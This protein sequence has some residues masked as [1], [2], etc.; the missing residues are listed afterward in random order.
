MNWDSILNVI[1]LSAIPSFMA[2]LG[3]Y[4]ATKENLSRREK[5]FFIASFMALCVISIRIAIHLQVKTD[6]AQEK[7]DTR[8]TDMSGRMGVLMDLVLHPPLNPQ[9]S[10][11]IDRFN[12]TQSHI[13]PPHAPVKTSLPKEHITPTPSKIMVS[14]L[15]PIRMLTNG[16]L[17]T[18]V[19]KLANNMRDFETNFKKEE[20]TRDLNISSSQGT[21]AQKQQQWNQKV[22]QS[23]LRRQ[24]YD[25]EF[26]KRYQGESISYRDELLRR[27][28]II[29]PQEEKN[30]I[31]LQGFLA[32]PSP[33]SD[34][35]TYLETLARQLPE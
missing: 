11:F 12:E 3:G 15:A 10:Q 34:L 29:A 33:I 23:I 21:E 5:I 32:G 20:Y 7:R 28:N 8:I 17:K 6:S 2:L 26:R 9:L 4:M 16:E 31:A 27:L 19:L 30:V 22:N 35:S 13:I 24:E 25:N 1:E 18:R 14:E